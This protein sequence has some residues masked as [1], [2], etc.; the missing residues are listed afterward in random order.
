[1]SVCHSEAIL[2]FLGESEIPYFSYFF[3]FRF[4]RKFEWG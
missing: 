3:T 4:D 2:S 1:M